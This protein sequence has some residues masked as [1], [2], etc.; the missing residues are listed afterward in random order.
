MRCLFGILT[1]LGI[2]GP[3]VL[4]AG[5]PLFGGHH[6][7]HHHG[8]PCVNCDPC[9]TCHVNPC[10]CA[11][12]P[13]PVIQQPQVT[14]V[15][16]T[17]TVPVVT[18]RDVA[19]TEYRT[20]AEVQTVPVQQMKTVM[21]DEGAWQQVWVSKMVAKQIPETIYQQ[22]TV[23]RQVPYQVTQRVQDV[24][25]QTQTRM[26]PR[27]SAAPCDPCGRTAGAAASW[28][29][30][31]PPATAWNNPPAPVISYQ[32]APVTTI[33]SL[34]PVYNPR[35][36]PS[37]AAQ[38]GEFGREI[39]PLRSASRFSSDL[40]PVPDPQFTSRS[41][42][43]DPTPVAPARTASSQSSLFAPAPSAASVWQSRVR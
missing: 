39:E 14:L 18:Y 13:V 15:P 16:E 25:Y 20:Q 12:A 4:S 27:V 8:H 35:P 28:L 7:H 19:R 3:G 43:S 21:V 22:Q 24:S 30:A 38:P 37:L 36:L 2:L 42:Y 1:V 40:S 33:S 23:Y 9:R 34:P 10:Q 29:P 41:A 5:N 17:Q 11:P 6:H 32:S 31:N 26:V